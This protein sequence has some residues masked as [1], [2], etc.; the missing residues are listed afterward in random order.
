MS[1]IKKVNLKPANTEVE[2]FCPNCRDT[3]ILKIKE[4]KETYPVRGEEIE[5]DAVVR[6]CEQCNEVIFDEDL[7]TENINKAF[8]KY[9]A[10]NNYL[11]PLEI[12]VIRSKYV[13]I[14]KG[15]SNF[16]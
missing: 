5:V 13:F 2:K 6:Y 10:L 7:D 11:S 3:K 12:E 14:S 8:E 15:I 1:K 4:I 9:R 16:T